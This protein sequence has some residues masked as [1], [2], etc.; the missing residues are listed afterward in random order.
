MGIVSNSLALFY[1]YILN[2]FINIY[3]KYDNNNDNCLIHYA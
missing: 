1:Y 3:L 2:I